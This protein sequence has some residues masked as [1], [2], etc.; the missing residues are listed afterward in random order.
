[1]EVYKSVFHCR[2][3]IKKRG[4]PEEKNIGEDYL[5]KVEEAINSYVH[6]FVNLKKIFGN[7]Q[8]HSC[9]PTFNSNKLHLEPFDALLEELTEGINTFYARLN[10]Q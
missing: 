1:V 7:T 2:H 9:Y 5:T 3:N 4:R 8:A 10:Q 6:S